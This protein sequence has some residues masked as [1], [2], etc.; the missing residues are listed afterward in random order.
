MDNNSFQILD[1]KM[2]NCNVAKICITSF[3]F[4]YKSILH[5]Y[6]NH[7]T[8]CPTLSYSITMRMAQIE[9]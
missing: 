2:Q 4:F 3:F 5:I 1:L 6:E 8:F 9:I 7:S